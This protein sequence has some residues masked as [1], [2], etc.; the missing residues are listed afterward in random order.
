[1]FITRMWR[2][3]WSPSK[4]AAATL[5]ILGGLGGLF[6]LGA[7]G[8][9]LEYSNTEE[10]CIGCHEMQTVYD[11][12]QQSPHA[13][14]VSG[15][16]AICSDCHVPKSW[17]P[18]LVRKVRAT[19]ELYHAMLGTIDTPEKFES[20][21]LTMARRVWTSME[22]S[23][24]LEC[25]NCHTF[26]RMATAGQKP[27]AAE[28]HKFGID[29]DATCI[30]CHKG[31][32]HKMPDLKGAVEEARTALRDRVDQGV[33]AA[34]V[35]YPAA[36]VPL[37]SEPGGGTKLGLALAAA[38]LTVQE[39]KD[40]W[41]RVRL[42]GWRVEGKKALVFAGPDREIFRA[43]LRKPGIAQV[44]DGTA[45]TAGAD[46]REWRTAS[47]EGWVKNGNLVGDVAAI[48]DFAGEMY[49][50]RC[51]QCHAAYAPARYSVAEWAKYMKAMKSYVD[52]G[53]EDNRLIQIYLQSHAGPAAT[54]G[55][56]QAAAR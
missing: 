39:R 52:L 33:D 1:M 49:H 56:A 35:V 7:F 8:A 30:D 12:Y 44:Q 29:Q 24:S 54:G 42:E 31:I 11:E 26:D 43:G 17:G 27:E 45:P 53:K 40:G 38:P 6:A 28:R 10:F 5:L 55:D 16:S 19:S 18:K 2:L 48:W 32:A 15:V 21:R 46:T 4:L 36:T 3:L 51:G 14:N 13:R 22:A 34:Q 47:I 41:L 9:F 23:D 20:H 25:R 37:Q 50:L